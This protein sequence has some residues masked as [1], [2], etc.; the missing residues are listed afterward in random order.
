[1]TCVFLAM[2][3]ITNFFEIT[4]KIP[5]FILQAQSEKSSLRDS[6]HMAVFFTHGFATVRC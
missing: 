3:D 2:V 6:V 5:P 4:S 1:M